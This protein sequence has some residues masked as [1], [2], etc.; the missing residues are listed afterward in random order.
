MNIED[1]ILL[2]RRRRDSPPA[3]GGGAAA[4]MPA[5]SSGSRARKSPE[6]EGSLEDQPTPPEVVRG[7]ACHRSTVNYI[8]HKKRNKIQ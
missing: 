5:A 2:L 6:W 3:K 8:I 4:S 7:G 1:E